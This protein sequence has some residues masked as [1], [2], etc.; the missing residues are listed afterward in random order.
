MQESFRPLPQWAEVSNPEIV[1]DVDKLVQQART[2]GHEVIWVLHANPTTAG[3]FHPD[4]G[5]I[6]VMA[7]LT[8]LPEEFLCTKT[9]KNAFSTTNLA[10][11]LTQQGIGHL[12]IVGI[13]TEQ[14]CETTARIAAD[15]GYNVTFVSDATATF[16][17]VRPDT[18]AVLPTTA[19]IERTEAVLAGRFARIAQ[20]S[21]LSWQW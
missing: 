17:L 21:T 10:Q 5:Q 2:E 13:Q 8:P 11:Y 16:P 6:R 15:L 14:C 19:I 20:K 1:T 9:S 4:S 7:E 3:V 12:V 18:G